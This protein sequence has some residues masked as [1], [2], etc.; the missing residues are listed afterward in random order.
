MKI[1]QRF[2]GSIECH[3][4][5][6]RGAFRGLTLTVLD[7]PKGVFSLFIRHFYPLEVV[8]RCSQAQRQVGNNYILQLISALNLLARG[9]I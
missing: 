6:G 3:M 8:I 5:I 4:L 7:M 9:R 2:K 1:I